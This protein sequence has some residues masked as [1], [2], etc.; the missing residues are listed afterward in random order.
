[1]ERRFESTI[2]SRR[3]HIHQHLECTWEDP[4]V[5]E[6]EQKDSIASGMTIEIMTGAVD[7]PVH[8]TEGEAEAIHQD[9]GTTDTDLASSARR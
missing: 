5:A 6:A 1:M 9:T 3:E 8:V 7:L 2:P 4:P